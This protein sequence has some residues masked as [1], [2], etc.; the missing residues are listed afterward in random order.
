MVIVS[1]IIFIEET[2]DIHWHLPLLLFGIHKILTY[3]RV[4]ASGVI[5]NGSICNT[6]VGEFEFQS[7]SLHLI[8][9]QMVVLI[10]QYDVYLEKL[11]LFKKKKILK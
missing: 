6:G 10:K 5:Y 7:A 3:R 9:S 4:C 8:T 11:L 2:F 1:L